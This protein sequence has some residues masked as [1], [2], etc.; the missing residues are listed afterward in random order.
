MDLKDIASEKLGP[1]RAEA[2]SQD[3][4]QLA[5]DLERIR[6]FRIELEDEP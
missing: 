2:L 5:E 6:S 3:L 4:Q 1:E